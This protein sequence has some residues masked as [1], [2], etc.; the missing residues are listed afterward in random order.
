MKE[1]NKPDKSIY[2]DFFIAIEKGDEEALNK[3]LEEYDID[4]NR[5]NSR[6]E[7]PTSVAKVFKRDE[8]LE[9]LQ[10]SYKILKIPKIFLTIPQKKYGRLIKKSS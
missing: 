4:V 6:K 5:I 9:I 1:K 7:L 10:K 8:I 3:I 2:A